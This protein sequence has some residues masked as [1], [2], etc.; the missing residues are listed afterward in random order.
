[1]STFFR[2]TRSK[3]WKGVKWVWYK[4]AYIPLFNAPI[5]WR[6]SP[7]Y[8]FL[9][10]PDEMGLNFILSSG[11]WF[12]VDK[13][14]RRFLVNFIQPR[15]VCFDIGANQ[16]FFTILLSKCVGSGGH[17]FAFEP[18]GIEFPKLEKIAQINR[19]NNVILEKMAVGLQGGLVNMVV[20]LNGHGSR[21]SLREPPSEVISQTKI[22]D[23]SITTLD[24]YVRDS[25]IGQI[26]F[27]KID[28]EGAE[29]EIL[30]G[31]EQVL[32]THRP[33]LMVELADMAT[34]QFGYK[35]TEIYQYLE[36][37][38]FVWFEATPEGFL[39]AAIPKDT[40]RENLFAVPKE[41]LAYFSNLMGVP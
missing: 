7:G 4:R 25:N 8:W 36:S 2:S 16:G 21:S 1:M 14:E 19:V 3:V 27:I 38:N 41:K 39:K 11:K 10:Y 26:D 22:E 20:C 17:V 23:V 6:F 28:T 29:L 5:P 34:Q 18:T 35:A 40:Y 24:A 32:S 13:N 12:S 31:G 33:L 15:M 37:C 30:R 9:I